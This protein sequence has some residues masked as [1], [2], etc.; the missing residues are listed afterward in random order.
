MRISRTNHIALLTL[1]DRLE[2]R[3]CQSASLD[4]GV[5]PYALTRLE[6]YLHE[7]SHLAV[8]GLSPPQ[9]P[10]RTWEYIPWIHSHKDERVAHPYRTTSGHDLTNAVSKRFEVYCRASASD[11]SELR[12]AAVELL[13]ARAIRVPLSLD[14]YYSAVRISLLQ[15]RSRSECQRRIEQLMAMP[16]QHRRAR[17]VLR[18]LRDC[19][20][21]PALWG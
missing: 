2:S 21:D 5:V 20:E 3:Y 17:T 11:S 12:T 13:V 18:W 8:F 15:R 16:L 9:T 10:R 14:P 4:N 6:G 7:L 19:G 1:T